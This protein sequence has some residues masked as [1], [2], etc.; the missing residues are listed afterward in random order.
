MNSTAKWWHHPDAQVG[1]ADLDAEADAADLAWEVAEAYLTTLTHRAAGDHRIVTVE[2][3]LDGIGAD[4]M[5][6]VQS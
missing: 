1:C 5:T 4:D 3:S 2:A 6:E